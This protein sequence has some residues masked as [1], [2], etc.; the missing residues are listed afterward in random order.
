MKFIFEKWWS[1]NF[2]N[3]R[4]AS[5]NEELTVIESM[6]VEF[7]SDIRIQIID[8]FLKRDYISF[9]CKLVPV[10]GNYPQRQQV[11]DKFIKWL[12]SGVNDS[13]GCDYIRCI[14]KTYLDSDSE[15]IKRYF[16]DQGSIWFSVPSE[17]FHVDKNLFVSLIEEYLS[18]FD[19]KKLYNYE[20]LSYLI[21]DFEALE[22]LV[23]NLSKRQSKRLKKFCV[24]KS[25]KSYYSD[26]IKEK[27]KE[28]SAK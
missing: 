15:L 27:L 24:I 21:D 11:R 16:S 13:D 8:E 22:F 6:M 7:D 10:Y 28:L 17:L 23:D 25:K 2:F 3:K 19:N 20:T 26:K 9:V 1:A 4:F 18:K 12:D 5:G 14:L